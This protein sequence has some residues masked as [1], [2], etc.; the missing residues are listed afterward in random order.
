M[1][2]QGQE[3]A[4]LETVQPAAEVAAQKASLALVRAELAA[5]DAAIESNEASQKPN[6]RH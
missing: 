4:K 2:E 5:R 3:L 1:V 6:R